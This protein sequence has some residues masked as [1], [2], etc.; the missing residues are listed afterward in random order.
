MNNINTKSK[1]ER[2]K[3][4]TPDLCYNKCNNLL[5]CIYFNGVMLKMVF[6]VPF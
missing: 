6:K 2:C 1:G 5:Y 3:E 4:F